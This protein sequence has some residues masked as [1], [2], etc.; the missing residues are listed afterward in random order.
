M[1]QKK[2]LVI[3]LLQARTMGRHAKSK[4]KVRHEY[5]TISEM[6]KAHAVELYVREQQKPFEAERLPLQEVCD[7][8]ERECWE[9]ENTRIQ[10]SKSSLQRWAKGGKT[11]AQSNAE[12][13]W[14]TPEEADVLIEYAI[15]T[16]LQGHGFTLD[17]LQ[18]HANQILRARLGEDFP[19][20]GQNWVARF[21]E[22]HSD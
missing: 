12:K 19:G 7:K 15:Q 3:L 13:S 4:T 9:Q 14:I 10:V 11:K 18:E 16:A 17:H 6:W 2:W 21:M 20:V 5:I 22:K 1:S 8:V